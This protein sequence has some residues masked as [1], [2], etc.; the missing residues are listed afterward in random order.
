MPLLKQIPGTAY[1][2]H[3][4]VVKLERGSDYTRAESKLL[5]AVNSVYS[6]YRGSIEEQHQAIKGLM[7]ITPVVPAPQARLQLTEKG[8]NLIV[9]YPVVLH[10]ET[11][12]DNQMAKTVVELIQGDAELKEAVGSPTIQPA[13]KA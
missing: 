10:R 1:A 9:R 6:Q 11:E 5:E 8:L 4:V 7:T 3:E 13:I 2:W 12:I